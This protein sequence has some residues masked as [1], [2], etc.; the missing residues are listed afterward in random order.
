MLKIP[1]G[2]L[3]VIH[4]DEH[5]IEENA[6]RARNGGTR[7]IPPWTVWVYG[8]ADALPDGFLKCFPQGDGYAVARYD[9]FSFS[10][11]GL[12][13]RYALDRFPHPWAPRSLL[14][15]TAWLEGKGGV[16]LYETQSEEDNQ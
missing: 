10:V 4:S 5:A 11:K 6:Q 8:V 7:F 3:A 14:T 1:A 2:V 9:A 15:V 12:R 16:T 13:P